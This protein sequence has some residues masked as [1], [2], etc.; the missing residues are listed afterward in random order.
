[1]SNVISS[2][3]SSEDASRVR[4]ALRIRPLNAQE[5]R[6]GAASVLGVSGTTVTLVDPVAL[7]VS[8]VWGDAALV[9]GSENSV[10]GRNGSGSPVS[11]VP[12]LALDL[13]RRLFSFDFVYHPRGC[14]SVGG[15]CGD[16]VASGNGSALQQS[17]VYVDVGERALD[18]AW[19][20]FNAS[21]LAYGQTGSGKSYTMLGAPDAPAPQGA[22][23]AGI[24]PRLCDGLF[25]RIKEAR[26]AATLASAAA[27]ATVGDD[28]A[29][30]EDH[31]SVLISY[32]EIYCERVRDLLVAD[33]TEENSSTLSGNSAS[34]AAAP[35]SRPLGRGQRG[36]PRGSAAARRTTFSVSGDF[37][38]NRNSPLSP[39]SLRV[40]EHP[41]QGV[42]VE[43]L[44]DVA[45]SSYE[46]VERLLVAGSLVRA[47]AATRANAASSRSHA[48]FSITLR[49]R[50]AD[51]RTGVVVSERNAKIVLVDLAGSERG[52]SLAAPAGSI[53]AQGAAASPTAGGLSP[54]AQRSREMTKINA[55]LS[56]LGAVIKA[57]ATA[58][59]QQTV[60][61]TPPPAAPFIPYRNSVLTWL[62]RDALGGNSVTTVVANVSPADSSYGETLSTLKYA[63]SVS[64][65]ATRPAIAPAAL[66]EAAQAV[67]AEL[68]A[69][70]SAL[71]AAL[72]AAGGVQAQRSV[73]KADGNVQPD[74]RALDEP[75]AV[76]PSPRVWASIHAIATGAPL[77]GSG[78]GGSARAGF[79]RVAAIQCAE[80]R[81][82]AGIRR[83]GGG[84]LAAKPI[85]PCIR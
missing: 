24:I 73:A 69:E 77:P 18:H 32:C 79:A 58:G 41:T 42:F 38:G 2:D 22:S 82:H 30:T 14:S 28:H 40:R 45:V 3:V 67:I 8:A 75:V 55:S 49:T 11:A 64:R 34:A 35:R 6:A 48:L 27:A 65:I 13:P 56:A 17:R 72:A 1:M 53:A 44:R 83:G 63:E 12:A 68:R 62:L 81:R 54:P 21:V 80:G 50:R 33:I 46:E 70:I 52:D 85:G 19:R 31:Y 59:K 76:V 39:P 23:H 29:R 43:G 26:A 51:V 7:E 15:D 16:D 37:S 84:G 66:P 47:V 25:T 20:G 60:G 71:R 4:V 61:G 10:G 57:L 36:D 78:I 9:A 5:L 74:A